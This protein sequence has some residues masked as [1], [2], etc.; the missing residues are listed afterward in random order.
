MSG[1]ISKSQN[2]G[3]SAEELFMIAEELLFR[4]Q[5]VDEA[6]LAADEL[7]NRFGDA[8]EEILKSKA[9]EAMQWKKGISSYSR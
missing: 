5:R 9:R 6:L 7:I 2:N 8:P 4:L 3:E 1:D